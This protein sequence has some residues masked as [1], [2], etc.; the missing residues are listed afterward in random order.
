MSSVPSPSGISVRRLVIVIFLSRTVLNIAYRAVYPFLPFIAA[1]L[2]VSLESAAQIIQ[3]RNLIGLAAPLF[4][5]LSDHYGRRALMLVGLGISIVA[6]LALGAFASFLFAVLAVTMIEVGKI[7]YDP[8]QAAYLGD[9]VPY[10]Q[11]GRAIALSEISWAA[12]LIALPIFALI[13]QAAGWRAAFVAV[14]VLG[15]IMFALTR[16]SLPGDRPPR[17]EQ[18][19]LTHGFGQIAREPGALAV[20]LTIILNAAS[21]ENINI[22][23]GAWMRNDFALDAVA[24]GTV[25][26][27]IGISELGGE[28]FSSAFVDRIGKHR[29]TELM[30]LATAG[31]YVLLPLIGR[32]VLLASAGLVLA[33][34]FFEVSVVAALPL[35]TE[36]VPSA[37][38]TL[39]S[40][41]VAG[42]S[43]GRALGSFTG[44]FIY[45]NNGFVVNGLVS[46]V[47]LLVAFLIWSLWVHEREGLP[48]P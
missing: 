9:R 6:A 1:D 10:S 11:R 35:I 17:A 4:G 5:P 24:L 18:R 46:G 25:A 26:S 28:L 15:V 12:A 36:M 38:A 40:M 19:S 44:P 39:M 7:I 29:L 30:L 47:G 34:F 42:F 43:L 37:R 13:L 27:A 23:F 31:A 3:S 2:N 45:L 22:V 41:A 33:F 20:L 48:Q 14:G 21:N 16:A 8:A 32:T